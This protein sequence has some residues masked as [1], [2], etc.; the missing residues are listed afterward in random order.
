MLYKTAKD[1]T[2]IALEPNVKTILLDLDNTCYEYEPCHVA[3]LAEFKKA[4]ENIT[5]SIPDF[6]NKYKEAQQQVKNRIPTSAASHS[7]IL[8]AQALFEILGRTDGH[9][10][11]PLIEKAYWDTFLKTM[12]K[13]VGLNDFLAN[14]RKSGKTI[15]VVSD[16]TTRVQCQKLVA[17]NIAESIDF[18]V[19]SEEVGTE[20]PDP[21]PFLIALEKAKSDTKTSIVIGDN[22]ERDIK[23]AISLNIASIMITHDSKNQKNP[24]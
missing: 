24:I 12:K 18:L 14:C 3:A 7:R 17:L 20:K 21:K 5:G 2:E 6:D 11:A 15:V 4:T 8:Y 23:V 1:F 9:I 19:T 10:H 16:L 22:Y 13:S